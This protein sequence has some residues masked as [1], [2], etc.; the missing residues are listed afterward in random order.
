MKIISIGKILF[1]DLGFISVDDYGVAI[2]LFI[3]LGLHGFWG[4]YGV[5]Y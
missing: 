5:K 3:I 4:I 1:C 2:Y